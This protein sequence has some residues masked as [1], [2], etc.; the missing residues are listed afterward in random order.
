MLKFTKTQASQ[1]EAVKAQDA[2]RASVGHNQAIAE[3]VA[4]P[5][6]RYKLSCV[7]PVEH[8]RAEFIELRNRMDGMVARAQM[9]AGWVPIHGIRSRLQARAAH[10]ARATR[11]YQDLLARL[12]AIPTVEKW[13]EAFDNLVTTVGKNDL[14]TNQFKGSSYTA[15]WY[16]GL[17]DNAG[18][19][20]VAAGD[21]MSSH[22]GWTE[23]TAYSDGARKT[24]SFGT[25][26]SASLAATAASFSINATATIKGAFSATNSTKGG[27]TGTLYSAGAFSATRNVENG[28]TLNVTL[29]VTV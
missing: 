15:A 28:D 4:A 17:I 23:S 1:S 20:A 7:S 11:E 21:T 29:T 22:A 26:S 25:A 16:L 2:A 10:L 18:Y 19:T 27:T 6:F 5:R 9:R 14:L 13:D 8:R 3:H 12:E 24:L